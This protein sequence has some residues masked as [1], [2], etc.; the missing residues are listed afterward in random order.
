MKFSRTLVVAISLL[1]LLPY[2]VPGLAGDPCANPCGDALLSVG[3][4]EGRIGEEVVVEVTGFTGCCITGL[5]MGVG[6]DSSKLRFVSG[7]P[8]Q[9]LVDHAGDDLQFITS[10]NESGG[11]VSLF[12]F[13]DITFPIT[14]PPIPIPE[15]T[16]L[17][18][19]R[20][21]ILP[22]AAPGET[23]LVNTSGAFGF[24]N[25]IANVYSREAGQAPLAPSLPDGT[26]TILGDPQALVVTITGVEPG[27]GYPGDTIRIT[28]LNFSEAG[29]AVRVCGSDVEA[30]LVAGGESLSVTA[31]E[32]DTVGDVEVEVCNEY[33][34]DTATFEYGSRA[35]VE[36]CDNESDDDDDGLIDCDDD[37]CPPCP[38]SGFV[39]GDANDDNEVNISDP[40]YTLQWLFLGGAGPVCQAAADAN[41]DGEVNISDPTYTLRFLF[42]GGPSHPELNGCD[43]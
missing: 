41:G 7:E 13:L 37:D 15:N 31:P 34:C 25:P 12:A 43:L 17:A 22:G 24:P 38:V 32:C 19:L 11:Y 30:D 23:A 18:V 35:P 26:V 3:D 21:G 16:V 2:G 29:L 6:H 33:G 10:A 1:A 4:A 36:I 28:G 27:S 14:V 42:L 39:R 20:Y 9:F 40:T 8:G 5:S